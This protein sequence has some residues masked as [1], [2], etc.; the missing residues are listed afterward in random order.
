MAEELDYYAILE[1]EPAADEEELRLAYRRLARRYHPDIAGP[2][3]VNK[4]QEINVAYQALSD[5]ERRRAYDASLRMAP[6]GGGARSATSA[7]PTAQRPRTGL[8]TTM[9]GPLSLNRQFSSLDSAPVV[10]MAFTHDG[11]L[12][13]MGQL[14][15]RMTI[16]STR[17]GLR[18][19]ELAFDGNERVGVLHSLRL[20]PRGMLACAW[21]FAMGVR[22]W[23]IPDGR[24]LWNTS[25]SAPSSMLDA[26]LYDTAPHVRLAT[27]D[28]PLAVAGDD[29]FEWVN[30]GRR[31]TAVYSRP[32]TSSVNMA[33]LTPIR[34]R[35]D[36]SV[37]WLREPPDDSWRVHARMLSADG[38]MLLT[39]STGRVAGVGVANTVQLWELD[40][41]GGVGPLRT[42]GPRAVGR[43]VE[44]AGVLRAPLAATP[45]L[46][47]V[48]TNSYDRQARLYHFRTR[49]SRFVEVGSLVP[50][51]RMALSHDASRLALAQGVR[52]RLF[53]TVTGGQTQEWEAGD[54]ITSLAFFAG[55]LAPGLGVG[56]RNGLAEL[57]SGR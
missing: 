29:P 15:G 46:E 21:G 16:V 2:D 50:D 49:L 26:M 3:A 5:P 14:D 43:L 27:P 6:G 44:P 48:A 4:M 53:D 36:G 31:A 37:G 20:S 57:W 56:L 55:S 25:M 8:R 13:A 9:D 51:A 34:C 10:A 19:S 38:R 32:L 28:A 35:E 24:V 18:V 1:V 39:A 22:V 11:A 12:C 40:R 30:T 33:W 47:W 7:P 41:R 17:D 23:S 54:E 45:D 42:Q 52:L